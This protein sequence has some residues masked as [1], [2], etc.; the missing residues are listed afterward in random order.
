MAVDSSGN[1]YVADNQKIRKI[2][3][4]GNVTTFAGSGLRG[5][6][7]GHGTSA[8][9]NSPQGVAV[10][11]SGNVYVSDTNNKIRKIDPSGM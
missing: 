4:S 9:F 10:D 6:T 7:D 1:V 2:D 3:P 5:T 8:S 11:S